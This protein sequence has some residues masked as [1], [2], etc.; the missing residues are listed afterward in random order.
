M[1][2]CIYLFQLPKRKKKLHIEVNSSVRWQVRCRARVEP[3]AP[4]QFS[5]DC[6]CVYVCVLWMFLESSR[7]AEWF[8]T[9]EAANTGSLMSCEF[10]S[11]SLRGLILSHRALYMTGT[12]PQWVTDPWPIFTFTWLIHTRP[13]HDFSLCRWT[14]GAISHGKDLGKGQLPFCMV[15]KWG[16]VCQSFLLSHIPSEFLDII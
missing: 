4:S 1:E 3:R 5:S 6:C 14:L 11:I 9:S 15:I 2:R 7:S 16:S 12:W 10:L 13:H 8:L